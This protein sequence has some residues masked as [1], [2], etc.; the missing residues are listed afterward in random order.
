[1]SEKREF[2]IDRHEVHRA[3]QNIL[4]NELGISRNQIEADLKGE[5]VRVADT[6]VNPDQ[7]QSW[8]EQAI[9]RAVYGKWQSGKLKEMIESLI[10]KHVRAMVKE[11]VDAILD[12]KLKITIEPVKVES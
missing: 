1:M 9:S 6:R 2:R 11:R 12:D 8:I 5:I 3:V 10:D 7:V 4:F